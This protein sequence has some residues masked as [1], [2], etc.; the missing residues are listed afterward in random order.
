MCVVR[1]RGQAHHAQS[2]PNPWICHDPL[3][4]WLLLRFQLIQAL[5]RRWIFLVTTAASKEIEKWFSSERGP[6]PE[7]VHSFPVIYS[8]FLHIYDRDGPF[9]PFPFHQWD[10]GSTL[11]RPSTYECNFFLRGWSVQSFFYLFSF[12]FMYFLWLYSQTKCLLH[13]LTLF[14]HHALLRRILSFSCHFCII[15]SER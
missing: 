10:L 6:N 14:L 9:L 2:G 8:F 13:Y 4:E 5:R 12:V 15:C 11:V 1:P 3:P 7:K